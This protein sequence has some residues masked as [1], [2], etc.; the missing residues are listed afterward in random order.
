MRISG[1]AIYPV[2]GCRGIEVQEF[3]LDEVGPAFDRRWMIVDPD[4]RFRS[5]RGH[6]RMA[7]IGTALHPDA[8]ELSAPGLSP[9]RIPRVPGGAE[10]VQVEVWGERLG[11]VP[12]SPE[13]DAWVSRALG[14]PSRLVRLDE[15]HETRTTD[16]A[17]APGYRVGFA[18]GYPLLLLSDAS[19]EGLNLRLERPVGPERFR[20]NVRVSGVPEPHGEDRWRRIRLGGLG[21]RVVKPCARCSV[22]AVD[23]ETGIPGREPLTTLAGYR[24]WEGKV[25]FGQNLVHESPGMIRVGDPVEVLEFAP[26]EAARSLRVSS[27]GGHDPVGVTGAAPAGPGE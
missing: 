26:T 18:D 10:P 13:A 14:D 1:L 16:P 25:W 19:M 5:Q 21:F 12:V 4:G 17:W 22:P 23:P 7:L 15:R 2:K 3:P 9:L 11:A 20:P 24:R 8:L 6:P 27:V